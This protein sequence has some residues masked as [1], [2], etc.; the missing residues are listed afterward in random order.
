[1][2]R[3]H[4]EKKSKRPSRSNEDEVLLV[5]VSLTNCIGDCMVK[6]KG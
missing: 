1:M 5:V 2:S 6:G 4:T 3:E